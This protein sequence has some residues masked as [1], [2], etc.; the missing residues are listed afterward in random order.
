M[1]T[2]LERR[3]RAFRHTRDARAREV[4]EDYVEMI[5]DLIVEFGEARL[6]DLAEHMGVAAPTASKVVRRLQEEGL[7]QNR[8]YRSLFL[9]PEGEA[10]ADSSRAR[11]A[12]VRDFLKALGVGEAAADTDS[13][14]MEHHVSDETLAAMQRFLGG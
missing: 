1:S 13:E 5:G 12:V 6:T 2:N 14:G 7:V 9:T 10:L 4:G 11:H 3:A 8:P